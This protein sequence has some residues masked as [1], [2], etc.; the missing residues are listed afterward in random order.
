[1]TPAPRARYAVDI[2]GSRSSLGSRYIKTLAMS[3]QSANPMKPT[4]PQTKNTSHVDAMVP[5]P[6]SS[7]TAI[8]RAE[9][10]Q[11]AWQHAGLDDHGG[12]RTHEQRQPDAAGGTEAAEQ[13]V[14]EPGI[15]R[16]DA[17][18]ADDGDGAHQHAGGVEER[19]GHGR[20]ERGADGE[21]DHAALGPAEQPPHRTQPAEQHDRSRARPRTRPSGAGRSCRSRTSRSWPRS[22][23]AWAGF[24][25]GSRRSASAPRT[26]CRRVPANDRH[27]RS[28]TS[29]PLSGTAPVDGLPA[30]GGGARFR[31]HFIARWSIPPAAPSG[32]VR[33]LRLARGCRRHRHRRR[34]AAASCRSR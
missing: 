25:G 7:T 8:E 22:R 24:P 5:P 10:A 29:P 4:K 31:K 18:R 9:P 2:A 13:Q 12:R 6:T 20:S 34:H 11:R 21:P 27:L 15:A 23:S 26:R 33:H 16:A 1:M 28:S 30:P 14:E 32:H 19:G 17:R 3:V